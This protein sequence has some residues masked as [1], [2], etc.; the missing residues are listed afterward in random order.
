MCKII[1]L[2]CKYVLIV[3]TSGII[4][5]KKHYISSVF[6][7][8][9]KNIVINNISRITDNDIVSIIYSH[10]NKNMSIKVDNQY[11]DYDFTNQRY[12]FPFK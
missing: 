3:D 12:I 4:R 6:M 9:I 8:Q 10:Y 2:L 5:I 1:M 7:L 11:N